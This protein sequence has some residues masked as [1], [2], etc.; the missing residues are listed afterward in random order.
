MIKYSEIKTIFNNAEITIYEYNVEL[1]E[2]QIETPL[3]VYQATSG[4]YFGADGINY[5]NLLNV[6]IALI[7]E[8]MNFSMQ[9]QIECVLDNVDISYDKNISFDDENRLYTVVYYIS[10]IDDCNNENIV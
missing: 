3:V 10:V 7:D 6:A 2:E 9:K 1:N 8:T 4:D 5:L